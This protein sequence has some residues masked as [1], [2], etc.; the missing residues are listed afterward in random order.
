M[1]IIPI[2][3]PFNFGI[4]LGHTYQT[5]FGVTMDLTDHVID[6]ITSKKKKKSFKHAMNLI[7]KS[8]MTEFSGMSNFA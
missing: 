8:N 4:E 7:T 1:S 3:S 2:I 5:V 6:Q